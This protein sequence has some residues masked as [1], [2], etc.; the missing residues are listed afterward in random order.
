MSDTDLL[1]STRPRIKVG[2]SEPSWAA[3]ALLQVAVCET[4][5]GMATL[6]LD[7][8]NWT[9]EG[10]AGAAGY[11]FEDEADL[12]LGVEI[13]VLAAI[14]NS[15]TESI[16]KGTVHAFEGIYADAEAP[17]LIVLAEDKT[18]ALRLKRRS[19]RY[20]SMTASDVLRQIA[21]DHAL[22]VNIDRDFGATLDWLQLG[23][24]DLAFVRRLCV[25]H[26]KRL[27]LTS[28][29]LVVEDG[30]QGGG[31]APTVSLDVSGSL[32][33]TRVLAD[34]AHQCTGVRVTGFDLHSGE[35]IDETASSASTLPGSGRSG[36]QLLQ[37][38][39]GAR[40][41]PLS[42]RAGWTASEARALAQQALD[43]RARRF[44]RLRSTALHEPR[45][46]CGVLVDLT[47]AGPRF[48]QRY[49]VSRVEHRFD[50]ALGFRTEFEAF[51]AY[52]GQP[53]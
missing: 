37:Q 38:A 46:H 44:L 28:S 25:T 14:D 35:A 6:E 3:N 27:R 10:D 1:T 31:S 11:A 34:L 7:L 32:I 49:V 19:A 42:H 47:G 50:M 30:A 22:S 40:V 45:L 13:E 23:E 17:R 26:G 41:E 43:D 5:E 9:A 51:G 12:R 48:S 52:L 15:T 24:T 20:Q 39:I 33:N 53:S 8:L 21:S 16:F 2:G 4:D 36:P 29:A 18:A